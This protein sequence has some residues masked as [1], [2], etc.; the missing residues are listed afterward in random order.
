ME[1]P[2]LP[3]GKYSGHQKVA[4]KLMDRSMSERSVKAE[5]MMRLL[6]PPLPIYAAVQLPAPLISGVIT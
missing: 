6:P 4:G 5:T 1:A 3:E 2:K